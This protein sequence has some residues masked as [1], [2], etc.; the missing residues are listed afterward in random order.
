MNGL[1]VQHA[2]DTLAQFAGDAPPVAQ[3]HLIGGDGFANAHGYGAAS[4]LSRAKG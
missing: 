3:L 4:N 2:G 1:L